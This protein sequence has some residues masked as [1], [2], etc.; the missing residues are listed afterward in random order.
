MFCSPFA[1]G[2]ILDAL[3]SVYAARVKLAASIKATEELPP[4]RR[5]AAPILCR[6]RG[7]GGA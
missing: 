1:V 3:R 4:S 5:Q 2:A 7:F 6:D